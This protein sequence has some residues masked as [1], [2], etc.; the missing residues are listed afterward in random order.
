MR[1]EAEY[2]RDALARLGVQAEV[3]KVAPWKTAADSLTEASMTPA[4]RDQYEWLL[5]S[6][7]GEMVQAI[8]AGRAL[9]EITVRSLIDAAPFDANAALAAGLVDA[10]L[11]EDELPAHL[12]AATVAAAPGALPE[13]SKP[14]RFKRYAAVEGLLYRRVRPRNSKRIG[15]LDLSGSIVSG[16]SRS[17]PIPLPLL[18]G[19]MLGSDAVQQAVRAARRDDRLAAI[20]AY[21]DSPGG[22]ALAS[23]IMW[24][25]LTL[26]AQEKP[27]VIYMGPVAASGGYYIA[28]PGSWIVAQAGTLTGSIGVITAKV[29][30]SDAYAK[31]AI[32]RD[33]VQRGANADLYADAQPLARWAARPGRSRG[34]DGLYYL[35]ATCGRRPQPEP[36]SG[37]RRCRRTAFGR[38]R[39]RLIA[40][41]WMPWATFKPRLK[42]PL[43]WPRCR[44][45]KSP[46]TCASSTWM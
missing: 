30:T 28:A 25:E 15:L 43:R 37:R 2:Y 8:V 27:L 13:A 22:S 29:I 11:Y 16:E 12:A 3:V 21:V 46:G 40:A 34:G 44:R 33:A 18:G 36:G 23:D 45:M 38:A 35:Q 20:V 6:L 4:A 26:L 9:D 32:G 31:L 7:Y 19:D 10:I 17:F 1:I 14:A 5:D 24:R 42:R 39:R 41:S